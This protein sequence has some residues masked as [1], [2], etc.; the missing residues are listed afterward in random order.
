MHRLAEVL[1]RITLVAIGVHAATSL[2]TPSFFAFF[3]LVF[4]QL[5]Q[6][7]SLTNWSQRWVGELQDGHAATGAVLLASLWELLSDFLLLGPL[8]R[9]FFTTSAA[10]SLESK[11]SRA[12]GFLTPISLSLFVLF[13]C[14]ALNRQLGATLFSKLVADAQFSTAAAAISTATA[15]FF[16]MLVLA[17]SLFSLAKTALQA[18][19]LQSEI[20][21]MSLPGLVTCCPLLAVLVYDVFGGMGM[22]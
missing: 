8:L 13:G 15:W 21:A 16:G 17:M 20:Q 6:G 5:D 14:R 4:A 12:F 1:T 7:L 18:Y 19:R 3:R 11:S 10:L 22:A 2:T 9:S